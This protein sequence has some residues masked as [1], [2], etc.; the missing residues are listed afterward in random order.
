MT[1][2]ALITGAAGGIGAATSEL[3]T[4]S[5]WE[6]V[7]VDKIET[8]EVPQGASYWHVDLADP[9]D[10]EDL[11]DRL[12]EKS[13]RL[14]ALVNNA[15][16]QHNKSIMETTDE[17]WEQVQGTNAQA[18]FTASKLAYPFLSEAA[19]AIV[20]VSSVHALATSINVA[21]YAASKGAVLALTRAM[22]LEFA[23]VGVRVNAV[24]PGAVDTGMLRAGLDRGHLSGP[25]LEAKLKELDA[26]IALGRVGRP[27]EIARTILFLAD[28]DQSSYITGASLVV[29]GGALA[30]LSTE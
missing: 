11:F 5:G 3:F 12:A 20:N 10:L 23:E 22:A 13:T 30:R 25:S 21:A 24:L 17:E 16:I 18:V 14:D 28:S 26:R 4:S 19:G 9:K 27:E 8:A 29:D 15:A 7:A 6:V 2:L 1:K